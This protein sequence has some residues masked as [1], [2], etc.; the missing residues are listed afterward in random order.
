MVG[1]DR[2]LGKSSP[3]RSPYAEPM[4]SP[5]RV[6]HFGD[7]GGGQLRQ[8]LG[9][10][11]FRWLA[12][13]RV[14]TMFGNAVAPVALAFAVLDLTGSP[15]SLGLVVGA[16]SLAN[17]AF[18]L[19]GGVIADRFP[20]QRVLVVSSTAGAATQA[21]IAGLILAGHA[22]LLWLVVLSAINGAVSAVALPASSA[23]VPQTVPAELRQTGNAVLRLGMNGALMAGA[24]LGGVLV[25]SVGA[26]WGLAVDAVTFG[27]AAVC[28]AFVVVPAVT[29]GL[30]ERVWT[31]LRDGWREFASR[32]W[33][34]TVVVGFTFTNASLAAVVGVLGPVV[35]DD[36]IGRTTWGLVLA[37]ET[38]GML[39]GG[40]IAMRWRPA[41]LLA[42]GCA[43][44][45]TSGLLPLALAVAPTPRIL[46][47]AAVLA[48]V[49]IEQFGVAWETSLQQQVPA[50]RLARVY[51][52]D[53]VGSFLAIPL[54]Q[55]VAGPLAERVGAR[56]TALGAA[57]IV[58]LAVTGML[59]SRSVRQLVPVVTAG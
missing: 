55:I 36:T 59:A 28:F 57:V 31:Q 5:A 29:G 8:L 27:V 44:V 53:A 1:G 32:R 24:A 49:G 4:P 10:G 25:A 37:A 11:P 52:Y 47:V 40:L 26:G 48:G 56:P 13:A 15:A 30:G 21:A 39:L 17:V 54:G 6:V 41:H 43:A 12:V 18:L 58:A 9:S 34:W 3:P 20:R 50:D 35:A 16:R 14:A 38:A 42:V 46:L 19:M 22:S 33:L 51:S 7:S 45:V 2:R 23:L